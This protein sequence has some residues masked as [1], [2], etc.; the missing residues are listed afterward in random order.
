MERP[1][2]VTIIAVFQFLIASMLILVAV[3]SAMGLGVLGAIMSRAQETGAPGLVGL[4]GA[5]AI[6][7][8]IL[9]CFAAF[10]G[11][12][13]YGMWTLRNWARIATIVLAVLGAL[14]AGFG[15]LWALVHFRVF[16]L[17]AVS[18]R[19]GI[20]LL[21]LW[22]LNQRHVSLAFYAGRTP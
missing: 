8:G 18:F 1:V 3:A 4:A 16:A 2:G 5:G 13:G 12:L 15:A 17:M 19:L 7:G 9:F 10:F 14:G 22:Y 21:I 6:I 20:N 11:A